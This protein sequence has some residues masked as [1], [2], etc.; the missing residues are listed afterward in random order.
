M[1]RV[2]PLVQKNVA[3]LEYR[4][5]SYA[6]GLLALTALVDARTRAF[7]VASNVRRPP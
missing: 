3:A 4:S 1:R 2:N 7:V 5:H 6:K